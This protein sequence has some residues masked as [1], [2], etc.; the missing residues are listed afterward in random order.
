MSL[1]PF[2]LGQSSLLR[3]IRSAIQKKTIRAVR[4]D[5]NIKN[6]DFYAAETR[7]FFNVEP[8]EDLERRRQ[9]FTKFHGT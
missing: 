7:P 8:L 4:Y 1:Q 2:I 5:K 6:F 9:M 3:A